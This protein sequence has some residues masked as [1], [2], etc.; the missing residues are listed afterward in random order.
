MIKYLLCILI[1]CLPAA[2][3]ADDF[4]YFGYITLYDG[5]LRCD[6][7]VIEKGD[8]VYKVMAYCGSADKTETTER[9]FGLFERHT[10]TYFRADDG[11]M[12]TLAVVI[13]SVNERVR[14]IDAHKIYGRFDRSER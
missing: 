12:A 1:L 8:S 11:E 2:V 10:R 7:E 14:S 5:V 9:L 6:G 3:S 13:D 4:G